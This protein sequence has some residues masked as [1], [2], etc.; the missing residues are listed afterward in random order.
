MTSYNGSGLDSN[1]LLGTAQFK[2]GF[3]RNLYG[4][5]TIS[6]DGSGFINDQ[7]SYIHP[8]NGNNHSDL[9]FRVS[10]SKDFQFVTNKDNVNTIHLKTNSD[11]I[12]ILNSF[13]QNC[14]VTFHHDFTTS[15]CDGFN[16][17]NNVTFSSNGIITFNC[18]QTFETVSIN[19]GKFK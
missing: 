15:N 11:K 19:Y 17:M 4:L 10:N 3:I 1:S 2:K 7:H 13:I 8:S 9:I 12:F 14:D 18:D 5:N 6:A 16:S